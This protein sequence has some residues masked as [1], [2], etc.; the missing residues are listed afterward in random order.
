MQKQAGNLNTDETYPGQSMAPSGVSSGGSQGTTTLGWKAVSRS[1]RRQTDI[2]SVLLNLIS[3]GAS[4]YCFCNRLCMCVSQ[5]SRERERERE[6]EK[7]RER[8]GD[9]IRKIYRNS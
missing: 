7:E 3:T 1:P 4:G 9:Q 6:G 2:K 5:K 8:S